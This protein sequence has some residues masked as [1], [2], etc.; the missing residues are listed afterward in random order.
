MRIAYQKYLGGSFFNNA[1]RPTNVLDNTFIRDNWTVYR[2]NTIRSILSVNVVSQPKL[3]DYMVAADI[4]YG[5]DYRYLLTKQCPV[6]IFDNAIELSRFET[7]RLKYV[8]YNIP[9]LENIKQ[10]FEKM[11]GKNG[12]QEKAKKLLGMG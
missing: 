5:I 8:L 1:K 9:M 3:S 6:S 10:T 12:K 7:E 2:N 11:V 4:R